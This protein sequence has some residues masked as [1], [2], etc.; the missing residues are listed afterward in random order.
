MTTSQV[1]NKIAY[2]TKA[3]KK[4]LDSLVILGKKDMDFLKKESVVDCNAV[5]YLHRKELQKRIVSNSYK[6]VSDTIPEKIKKEI[7]E[8]INKSPV[9]KPYIKANINI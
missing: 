4:C 1:E 5:K 7:I 2:Y 8:A 3:N 9:I 6:F